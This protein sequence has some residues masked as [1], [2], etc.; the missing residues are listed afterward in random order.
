MSAATATSDQQTAQDF[1]SRVKAQLHTAEKRKL[2][3]KENPFVYRRPLWTAREL[4]LVLFG[5]VVVPLRL[6]LV[7]MLVLAAFVF[8]IIVFI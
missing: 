3:L 5:V 8:V 2:D 7:T 4:V 6:M 1:Q